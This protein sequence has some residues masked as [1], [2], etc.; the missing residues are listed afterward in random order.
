[1]RGLAVLCLVWIVAGS[2]FAD[3]IIRY[4]RPES[5]HDKRNEYAIELLKLALKES[6]HKA[7]LVPSDQAMTQERMLK[8][9]ETGT[10]LQV[11]W[12]MTTK[13]RE[14]KALPIRIPLYKGLI[15]WRLALVHVTQSDLF[16]NVHSLGDL[17]RYTAGQARDWP[18]AAILQANDLKVTTVAGYENLFSMLGQNRFDYLPRSIGEIWSEAESHRADG[19]MID[20]NIV[21]H[22]PAAVYFF[23]SKSNPDLAQTL[24]VGLQRAIQNGK[25]DRLFYSYFTSAIE[26]ARLSERRVIELKNPDLPESTPLNQSHLWMKLPRATSPSPENPKRP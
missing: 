13:E 12:V 24:S 11:V 4:P 5:D 23:V 10:H 21:L 9:V 8:E 17:R 20:P 26:N 19:V 7:R 6:G 2:A 22:Y 18:D 15:G 1:M 3:E 16:A 14:Q 25:F